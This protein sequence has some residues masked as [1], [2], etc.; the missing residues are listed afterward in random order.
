[1]VATSVLPPTITREAQDTDDERH[2]PLCPCAVVP[3][4][5]D[6]SFSDLAA[7][8]FMVQ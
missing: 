4:L 2:M 5:P 3:R 8:A 1:M 7:P 6:Q